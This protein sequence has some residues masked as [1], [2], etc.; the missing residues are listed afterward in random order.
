MALP[1][2]RLKERDDWDGQKDVSE[3]GLSCE[4]RISFGGWDCREAVPEG[5]PRKFFELSIVSPCPRND[6]IDNTTK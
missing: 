5:Y 1:G 2:D 4:S 3:R 6:Y